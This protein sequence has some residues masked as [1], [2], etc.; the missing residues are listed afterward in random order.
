MK[1]IRKCVFVILFIGLIGLFYCGQAK[2]N[3]DSG[4]LRFAIHFP[5]EMCS[6]SLDGRMLLLISADDSREPRF[7][8]SNG[9]ETQM[10]FGID[11]NG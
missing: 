6:K 2:K 1:F 5:E 8:I 9:P 11:V 10:V 3:D 7:Q 4:N